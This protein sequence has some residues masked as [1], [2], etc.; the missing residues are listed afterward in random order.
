M[1]LLLLV[2]VVL[3]ALVLAPAALAISREEAN[4]VALETLKPEG[5]PGPVILFGLPTP[6]AASQKLAEAGAATAS[7]KAPRPAKVGRKA[8]LFWLDQAP[9]ARFQHPSRMLL[10]DDANGAVLKQQPMRWYPEIEGRAPPFLRTR[11]AYRSA[12]YRV[13]TNL[14]AGVFALRGTRTATSTLAPLALPKDAFKEDCLITIGDPQFASDI[15]AMHSFARTVGLRSF[16]TRSSGRVYGSHLRQAVREVV[17]KSCKD[18]FLFITGHGFASGEPAVTSDAKE[19]NG[20]RPI[21]SA[22]TL[23]QILVEHPKITF[24]IKIDSCYSG[25]FVPELKGRKN[26]LVL[27]TSSSGD[28]VSWGNLGQ[29]YSTRDFEP[30]TRKIANSGVS[31]FTNGNLHGMRA[32]AASAA[33]VNT[34]RAAGGSLLAHMI[35]RSFELGAGADFARTLEWTHPQLHSKLPS[36]PKPALDFTSLTYD[37]EAPGRSYVCAAVDATPGSTLTFEL[38]GEDGSRLIGTLRLPE[39]NAAR[40]HGS[41]SFRISSFGRY[42]VT[43]T[44]TRN[45]Q[46]VTRAR[47]IDVTAQPGTAACGP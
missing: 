1:R 30:A 37:H 31:E 42:T 39:K 18:V 32:F 20:T 46:S 34:A 2:A 10:V 29:Q 25:R 45:G 27:E 4:R 47:T 36:P 7:R 38:V 43:V 41:F 13:F 17:A 6:L 8:W 35:A 11:A 9:L 22:Q 21:V 16:R 14:P 23:R 26:L 12:T 44:A 33:E 19:A 24:K 3:G 28:E 5:S 40:A 15:T